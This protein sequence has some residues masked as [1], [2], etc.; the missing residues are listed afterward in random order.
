MRKYVGVADA[1]GLDTFLPEEETEKGPRLDRLALRAAFN[2][3]RHA[4]AFR[5]ELPDD[6]AAEVETLFQQGDYIKALEVLKQRA[7]DVELVMTAGVGDV[8]RSWKLIPNPSLDPYHE[9]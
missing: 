6:V 9:E 3:H 1:H 8:E 7:G 2:R 4:V 5:V